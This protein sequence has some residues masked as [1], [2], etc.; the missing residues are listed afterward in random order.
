MIKK[1]FGKLQKKILYDTKS[2]ESQ[3]SN[4]PP[5]NRSKFFSIKTVP[6][7]ELDEGPV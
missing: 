2:A 3:T 4:P 5:P 1:I 6:S 7:G